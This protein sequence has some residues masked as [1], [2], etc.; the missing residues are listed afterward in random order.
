MKT[1]LWLFALSS[2]LLLAGTSKIDEKTA[3]IWQDNNEVS[4]KSFSY[5]DARQYCQNLNVD[6]YT[7]W[8]LPSIKEFYTIVS[9]SQKRPALKNGFAVRD[10]G[11]YWTA[12]PFAKNPKN[13][14]WYISMRYGEIDTAK[15][16]RLNAV[17][18]VR[19]AKE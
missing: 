2:P 11:K 9:L 14:A 4:Q 6:G 12:T 18:C 15:R 17:R 8:R 10:D 5:D 13:E 3:L 7:D 19:D 16:T 1:V